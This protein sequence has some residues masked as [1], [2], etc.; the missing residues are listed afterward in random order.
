MKRNLITMSI[1]L[2]SVLVLLGCS[3][4]S[5]QDVAAKEDNTPTEVIRYDVEGMTCTGCEATVKYTLKKL[6]GVKEVEAS[7]KEG[8]ATVKVNPDKVTEQ[9]V[10]DAINNIGYTA[11]KK[12]PGSGD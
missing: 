2:A 10:T 9:E 12:D 8:S 3:S 4:G 5:K 7:Y 6:D 1:V 11:K